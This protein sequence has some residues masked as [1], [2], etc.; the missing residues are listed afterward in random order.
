[1]E[2]KSYEIRLDDPRW[3]IRG[4]HASGTISIEVLD[5]DADASPRLRTLPRME[6][7]RSRAYG[8]PWRPPNTAAQYG[9]RFYRSN[10]TF[11]AD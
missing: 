2:E 5:N 9:R 10:P 7:L 11:L 3:I 4:D 8:T 1:M 6:P